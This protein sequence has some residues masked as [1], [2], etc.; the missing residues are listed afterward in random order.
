MGARYDQ[1]EPHVGIVRVPLD[2]DITFSSTGE[3]GPVGVSINANGRLEIGN[4]GQSGII[5]VLVKNVPQISDGGY[6]PPI[7]ST[8][9]QGWMGG[10]AGDVVDVMTQGEILDTGLPAGRAIYAAANGTLS[11]T[12]ASGVYVG[13]TVEAGRLF[14]NPATPI[15][16]PS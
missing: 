3:F 4:A 16:N 7:G 15:A 14:V 6:V 8:L 9:F 10:K 1:V 12:A 2:D 11:A 5:G 13:F